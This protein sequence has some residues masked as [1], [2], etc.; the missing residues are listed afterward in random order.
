MIS[1]FTLNSVLSVYH[2]NAW[3]LSSPGLI[4]FGR[5]DSEVCHRSFCWGSEKQLR[6]SGTLVSLKTLPGEGC[7]VCL[8]PSSTGV[9]RRCSCSLCW[10]WVLRS[11]QGASWGCSRSC[12]LAQA[13]AA[14]VR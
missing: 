6:G 13:H 8:D 12:P 3:D 4:N 2:G 5:F 10:I 14:S 11:V 1:T 9:S 7:G